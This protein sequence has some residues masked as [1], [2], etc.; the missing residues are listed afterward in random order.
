MSLTWKLLLAKLI[1]LLGPYLL[2]WITDMLRGVDEALDGDPNI[3]EPAE[4]VSRIFDA[5]IA[6]CPW[7]RFRRKAALAACARVAVKYAEDVKYAAQYGDPVPR[8]TAEECREL[9]SL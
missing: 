4:A 7:W 1:E 2:E 3:L 5:A 6:R 9:E 8:L